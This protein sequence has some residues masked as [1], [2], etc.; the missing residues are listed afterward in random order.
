MYHKKGV[1]MKNTTLRF[2]CVLFLSLVGA[3]LTA[4]NVPVNLN[5]GWNWI[6]YP[7]S[8]AMSLE[9]AMSGFTPSPGDMIKG[10]SGSSVYQ[11]GSWQGSLD[12]LVPG[13]G[14]MYYST[15]GTM[16]SFVFGGPDAN[17]S[18]IPSEALDGEFTVDANGT[19]VRFSPGNLQYRIDNSSVTEAVAG[20]GTQ[21]NSNMPYNTFY[22]HSL[23]QMF[24]KAEE[25][26]GLGAGPITSIAFQSS[27]TNQYLRNG[28][29]I[30]MQATQNEWV[31]S[32]SNSLSTSGGTLVYSGSLTQQTGW[33]QVDLDVPFVWDGRSD[34]LLTVAMNHGSYDQ[35]TPW[36]CTELGLQASGYT[37]TDNA[38]QYDPSTS[39]YSLTFS[40]MR[41]NVRFGSTRVGV[42]WHFAES[43]TEVMTNANANISSDYKG[44]IDLF[45]WGTSGHSHGAA[46]YQPWTTSTDNNDYYAYGSSSYNLYDLTGEAD[47]GCNPIINGGNQPNQWRTLTK[48]EWNYVFFTRSTSSGKRYAKA[49]VNG[50]NGVILLPDNWSTS[51][52]N[53][54]S[55]NSASAAF[56]VNTISASTWTNLEQHGAVFLPVGGYRYGTEVSNMENG[57]YYSSSIK[58]YGD[59]WIFTV[60]A[61]EAKM[62]YMSVRHGINVRLVCQTNPRIRILGVTGVGFDGATVSAEVDFTGTVGNRGVCWNTT[63]G[64][65][66]SGSYVNAGTGKGSFTAQLT[67]LS[68]NTTYYIRAYCKIGSTYRFGNTLTYTTPSDRF[69]GHDYVDLGLPSGVLWATCNIGANNPED[70]GEYYSWAETWPHVVSDD[71]FYEYYSEDD[72]HYTKYVDNASYGHNGY[73]DN[74][75]ILLPEDDAATA[76]WGGVWRM[77]SEVEWQELLDNTTYTWTTQNNVNGML[78]TASNGYSLFLPAAGFISLISTILQGQACWY[79]S[80][81]LVPQDDCENAFYLRGDYL[82]G[83]YR[84]C[85]LSV[86]PVCSPR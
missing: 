19:K 4:Q 59:A 86:R 81:S 56:T 41:P 62:S 61:S 82:H 84:G 31:H 45:G 34:V 68:A 8:E 54:S 46:G 52:H 10:M 3:G 71:Y 36:Y 60:K 20:M 70:Y 33:T 1:I 49:R 37:C 66:V 13:Q 25:L 80:N 76:N 42:I 2:A 63:G 5:S 43:Q 85:G 57:Y 21:T 75:T 44:W 64:P 47:W 24:F 14:Y 51:Y 9:A 38:T 48:D 55:T 27:S 18:A 69:N 72:G 77:P 22:R 11:N 28:I 15:N 67:G 30:W 26:A 16:K 78:F 53:L 50:R 74:M 29:Q 83:E 23:C 65:T 73:V 6:S 35:S 79:W 7:R 40:T 39:T 32:L 12:E 17:P 58:D